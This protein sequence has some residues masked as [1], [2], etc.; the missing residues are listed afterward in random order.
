MSRSPF[1]AGNWKMHKTV[2]EAEQ[3]IQSCAPEISIQQSV[4]SLR[5]VKRMGWVLDQQGLNSGEFVLP[6]LP[7]N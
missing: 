3:F 2:D 7:L 1:I 4:V 5:Q 6:Q